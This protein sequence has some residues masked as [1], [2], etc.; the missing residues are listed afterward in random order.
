F[1][2]LLVLAVG[3]ARGISVRAMT[4]ER[5]ELGQA[6]LAAF[7][8]AALG[9]ATFDGLGFPMFVGLFFLLLGICG[10]LWRITKEEWEAA[11]QPVLVPRVASVPARRPAP[12][13]GSV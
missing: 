8:G 10:G 9:M 13:L 5:K 2:V 4:Q 12:V 3:A 6:F 7:I 1:I 11:H